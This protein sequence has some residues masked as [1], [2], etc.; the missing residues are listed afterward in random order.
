MRERRKWGEVGGG[1]GGRR[2]RWGGDVRVG[3]RE[4]GVGKVGVVGV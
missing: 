1:R 4:M 2:C 3:V